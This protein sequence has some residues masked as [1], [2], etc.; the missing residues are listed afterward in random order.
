[1][2][3]KQADID[4]GGDTNV[5]PAKKTRVGTTVVNLRGKG[6]QAGACDV[7]IGRAVM[8]DPWRLPA[9]KWANPFKVSDYAGGVAEVVALY[10]AHVRRTPALVAALPELRGKVLG[11]WCKPGPCH[12]DVLTAMA[13][14]LREEEEEV[15]QDRED[16]RF[17]AEQKAAGTLGVYSPLM[18][19]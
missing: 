9:S 12:G 15:L 6:G 11:C 18:L 2:K 16:R 19:A 14:D 8:R 3:R 17:Y 7:Y 4:G 13:E 1:M 5:A 10:A